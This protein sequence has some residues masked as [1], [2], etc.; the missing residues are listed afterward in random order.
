MPTFKNSRPEVL[1]AVKAYQE[2]QGKL[3]GLLDLWA[4]KFGM[5]KAILRQHSFDST[6]FSGFKT[7]GVVD[8]TLWRVT[9]TRE[10][11]L[12]AGIPRGKSTPERCR[13][14]RD[15]KALWE[16]MTTEIPYPHLTVSC[17]P[18]LNTMG[19]NNFLDFF[20][21]G[22]I[23]MVF[24]DTAVFLKTGET[25]EACLKPENG[26]EEI[27]GSQYE[28]ELAAARAEEAQREAEKVTAEK[29]MAEMTAQNQKDGFYD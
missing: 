7:T 20:G 10:W 13:Q 4:P 3:Q 24:T 2:D 29:A 17:T 27:L 8:Q 11:R 9:N 21:C 26:W 18:Y 25:L 19:F 12:R 22:G 23:S 14:L 1:T 5:E 16:Q 15:L 28:A 6:Y